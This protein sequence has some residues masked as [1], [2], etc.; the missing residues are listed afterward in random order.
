[1]IIM[2]MFQTSSEGIFILDSLREQTRWKTREER[3]MFRKA[4]GVRDDT[5]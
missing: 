5:L 1:M 2:N 3:E 4:L